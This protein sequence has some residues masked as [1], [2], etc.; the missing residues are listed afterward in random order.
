MIMYW[1]AIHVEYVC[2]RGKLY[3]NSVK[4]LTIKLHPTVGYETPQRGNVHF[5]QWC[6]N[7][8]TILL[9]WK[10]LELPFITLR[11]LGIL[12]HF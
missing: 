12:K 4:S 8:K 11:K 2:G 3:K 10:Q 6:K 1:S 7:A 9:F 5:R